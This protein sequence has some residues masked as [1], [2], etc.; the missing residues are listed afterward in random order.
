MIR[1]NDLPKSF[2]EMKAL[3]PPNPILERA[4]GYNGQGRWIATWWEP[5]CDECLINDG[6][7]CF[8]GNNDG[9]LLY[10]SRLSQA[11][12]LQYN[13]GWSDSQA[14]FHLLF[15]L[16][17]RRVYAAPAHDAMLFL[18][19]QWPKCEV[20]QL[21]E[22]QWNQL[23]RRLETELKQISLMSSSKIRAEWEERQAALSALRAWFN[24]N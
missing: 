2:V 12:I 10:I 14:E 19:D 15:D 8:N 16:E 1:N 17:Q 23:Q 11:Q 21:T 4:L 9:Y 7:I 5:G 6:S 3:V 22:E 20:I 24:Q 18:R 13:F